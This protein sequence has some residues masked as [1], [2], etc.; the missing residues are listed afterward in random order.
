MPNLKYEKPFG[1]TI[2]AW[3]KHT[4]TQYIPEDLLAARLARNPGFKAEYF[5]GQVVEDK[6]NRWRVGDAMQSSLIVNFDENT[7]LVETENTV[8]QLL[9]PGRISSARPAVY[10]TEVGKTILLISEAKG[11][12]IDDSESVLIYPER[13]N[14]K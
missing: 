12:Q 3:C 13:A 10:D 8:Y 6:L 1:G 5:T 11:L 9:G 14:T 4:I 2:R 7:M